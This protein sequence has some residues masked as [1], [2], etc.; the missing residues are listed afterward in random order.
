MPLT[1]Y[2]TDKRPCYFGNETIRGRVVFE[3]TSITNLHDIRVTFTGRSKAKV[4]KVKGAGAPAGNYRSR[5]A[6]FEKEKILLHMNG[7]AL[8]PGKY[9]WPFEFEFPTA[10]QSSTKWPVKIPY[11]SDENHPL[12]PTFAIQA[13]D[14]AR[15]V[16]CAIDYRIEAKV[17]KPQRGL[18]PS[19]APLFSEEVRLNFMPDFA[20][21]DPRED[22]QTVQLYRQQKEQ[23]FNIRSILLLPE[24]KGRSLSVGE[25]IR[26]W[27]APGQLPKFSFTASLSYPTRVVQS[28]PLHCFLNILPHMED[29]SVTSH[30]DIFIK[31]VS[32]TAISQTAARAAPSIKGAISAELDDK[33]EILSRPSLH[34]PVSGTVNLGQ[35][36]GPLV[37]R[38]TDVSFRTFNICRTYRLCTS[39]S[40]EC[41]GKTNEFKLVDLPFEVVAKVEGS[42]KKDL[43]YQF[44]RP[45]EDAPPAYA[46]SSVDSLRSVEEV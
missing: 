43:A 1:I 22:D 6:L 5:C 15:K 3:S 37:L 9:E 24:N 29:S 13:G 26:G 35:A 12:P 20:V 4:Q 44:P 32:I 46:S 2:I 18:F 25:K 14:E 38:H 16:S 30:P 45:V 19:K 36:F 8:A 21:S 10:A 42:E 7:E 34:M 11:R 41:A 33:I 23:V 40:F 39:I 17:M 27:F 31:S 28:T